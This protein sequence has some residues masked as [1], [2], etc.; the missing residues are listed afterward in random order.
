M[1]PSD[2]EGSPQAFVSVRGRHPHIRDEQVRDMLIHRFE[3]FDAVTHR[4]AHLGTDLLEQA[5][6]TLTEQHGI[7]S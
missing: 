4:R 1:L 5:D 2:V 7:F 3:K 6:K